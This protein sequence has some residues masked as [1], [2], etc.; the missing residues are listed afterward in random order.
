MAGTITRAQ[1]L[2][3]TKEVMVEAVE[4]FNSA[5]KLGRMLQSNK[6]NSKIASWN[7]QK[8]LTI[9]GLKPMTGSIQGATATDTNVALQYPAQAVRTLQQ[10]YNH[11][12][13]FHSFRYDSILSKLKDG[14]GVNE[15]RRTIKLGWTTFHKL[16]NIAHN[17][18]YSAQV[19][20]KATNSAGGSTITIPAG[21]DTSQLFEG[22]AV[23]FCDSGEEGWN[24]DGTALTLNAGYYGIITSIVE[25]ADGTTTLTCVRNDLSTG[26]A[27]TAAHTEQ[28]L[29]MLASHNALPYGVTDLI[30][31]SNTI[32]GISRSGRTN[33]VIVDATTN[34][35]SREK[36]ARALHELA[37]RINKR[38]TF[39]CNVVY[40]GALTAA[41]L[42]DKTFTDRIRYD[43]Q[44]KKL[45]FTPEF[46]ISSQLPVVVDPDFEE[47]KILVLPAENLFLAPLV[48]DTPSYLDSDDAAG[49]RVPGFAANEIV[50]WWPFQMG[51]YDLGQI[52]AI[53]NLPDFM[54]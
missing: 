33:P 42:Y 37:A 22:L 36:P 54:T 19:C 9:P 39:T 43:Q 51:L 5:H 35:M 46:A 24:E 2:E 1:L 34:V 27:F 53:T 14:A 3:L 50:I 32:A 15:L 29:Y 8:Q 40:C 47:G 31:E 44:G 45:G 52:G 26:A 7:G 25:N 4:Y 11:A 21:T 38:G 30:T 13:V 28:P 49:I 18:G 10:V 41:W 23:E 12:I 48:D 20:A 6:I 16:L 17:V